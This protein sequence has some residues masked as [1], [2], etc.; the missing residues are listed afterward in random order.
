[1]I[2]ENISF[3]KISLIYI[4]FLFLYVGLINTLDTSL[5]EIDF[6]NKKKLFYVNGMINDRGDL[7]IEYWGEENKIRYFIGINGTTGKDIYFGEQKVLE[8]ESNK[9]SNFHESIIINYNNED[10]VFSM[11]LENFDFINIK[12]QEFTSELTNT[13]IYERKVDSSFR[14]SLTKL[15]Q[16]NTYLLSLNLKTC[17]YI[18]ANKN[19]VNYIIFRFKTN[20]ISGYE[21]LYSKEV[22]IN[23]MNSTTCFQTENEIIVCS[24]IAVIPSDGF[25]IVLCS[26]NLDREIK[27]GETI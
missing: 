2:I 8:I 18:F 26:S 9:I 16:S 21:E 1:M 27:G 20:E 22:D 7:Y 12:K 14:N 13:L 6:Y 10:N 5:L 15:K 25:A 23:F 3:I 19:V 17:C 4:Y 11:S 24:Y